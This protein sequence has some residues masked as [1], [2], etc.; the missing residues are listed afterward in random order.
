MTSVALYSEQPIL[1]AGIEAV[2]AGLEDCTL[3]GVFTALDPLMEHVRTRRPSVVLLDVTAA[4]AFSTLSKLEPIADVA[5]VVL[6]VDAASTE[7]VSGALALGVR[8]I[9]RKSLPIELQIKCLRIVAGGDLWVEQTLREQLLTARRVLLTR[10]ERQLVGLLVQGLKNKE[11][12]HAMTLSEG[13]VKV[14]L[15]RL[16]QKLGVNDRFELAL[17]ALKN[18]LLE[19]TREPE[20]AG[21]AG[22]SCPEARPLPASY[23]PSFVRVER[24]AAGV[25][26]S[27]QPCCTLC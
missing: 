24:P 16:F 26:C 14:Y 17:L 2:V 9:L 20:P 12:A 8:G 19:A 4:V 21:T 25:T 1:T 3:S 15:T 6:W 11:I 10:R 22:D 7:L 23:L 5:P 27:T 18:F 13:T